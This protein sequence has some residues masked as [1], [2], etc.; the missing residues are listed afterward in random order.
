MNGMLRFALVGVLL[1]GVGH[2]QTTQRVSVDSAGIQG[3]GRS[4]TTSTSAD[5]RYVAFE[6][7]ATNLVAGDTNADS[8]VFVRDVQTSQTTRV[9]VDSS[10][11]EVDGHSYSCSISDDGRY[12]TFTSDSSGLVAGDTNLFTDVF[13]RDRQTSQT[14]RVSVDSAAVQGNHNSVEPT[15][16]ADG[17]YVAFISFATNLV[18]SDTNAAW[19]VFVHDRQTGQTVR[20]SVDSAGAQSG[21]PIPSGPPS[22][23]A[24]G[25]YVA[26]VSLSTNLV[27][28]DT[29]GMQDVFV[30]DLQL[31]LTTRVS[32]D[33]AGGQGNADA[34]TPSISSDG[35]YVAFYSNATNIVVGDNGAGPDIFVHDRVTAQT[36]RVSVSSTGAEG[37]AGSYY[38]SISADG[39]Y[40]AFF[41]SATNIAP[42]DTN[43]DPDV[44]VHDRQNGQTTRV[45]VDSS[46]VQGDNASH[47]PSISADGRFVAFSS[48]ASNLVS[49]D[50]NGSYDVFLRDRGPGPITR[51]CFG[52]GT[53]GACPCGNNGDP[54]HGCANLFFPSG[55]LLRGFGIPS[56]SADSVLLQAQD[57][58]GNV[59]VFFQ[60]SAQ[61]PPI[62]IDDGLGCVSGSIIRL[63]TKA[64]VGATSTYPQMGDFPVSVKGAVS[65]L[66]ATR[67]YQAF[68]RNSAALFCPP[69]GTNRTNGL[70]VIWTP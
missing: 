56:V 30:R 58:S 20:A 26:F 4:R 25:R 33:S 55:G 3:N 43:F 17:R 21:V 57:L 48:W 9:S 22:L 37:N 62:V 31:G 45:S 32:V 14:T 10:G 28:D 53:D 50:T 40:V 29:N 63:G 1:A 38:P 65:P 61:M 64:V 69:A 18:P 11:A 15:I 42:G 67:Y 7:E 13:V 16:S 12:V 54:G 46:G 47:D 36:T 19:D 66:G 41:S 27:P 24:D 23:S 49:G 5:G 44:F 68:Y 60:G 39:R 70:A 59:C 34:D 35:H 6:S 2:A 51:F 52:D 8:D